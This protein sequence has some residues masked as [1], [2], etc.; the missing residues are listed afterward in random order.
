[1]D[2]VEIVG[3]SQKNWAILLKIGRG[4]TSGLKQIPG[5]Q[6]VG[7]SVSKLLTLVDIRVEF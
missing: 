4:T 3:Q 6:N 1:M 7:K 2:I 5:A